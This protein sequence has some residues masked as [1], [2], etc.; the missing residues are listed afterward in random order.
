MSQ[1]IINFLALTATAI[2]FAVVVVFQL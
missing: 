2:V 1:A